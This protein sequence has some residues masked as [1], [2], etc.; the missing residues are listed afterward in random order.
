MEKALI[1]LFLISLFLL[2]KHSLALSCVEPSPPNIAYN[3]YDAVVIGTVEKIK[4]RSHLKT[5]TI[6]VDKSFKAVDQKVITVKED[7]TWGESQ[8]NA[9]YLFYLNK[10]GGKWV[11]PLC[12]S[13]TGNTDIADEFFADKEE[14]TLENADIAVDD[15]RGGIVI[16]FLEIIVVILA[17]GRLKMMKKRKTM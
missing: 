3:E 8:L 11:H 10:E 12:S 5:L 17:I 14:I 9:S 13:T 6:R 4:D 15:T 16:I 7:G 1:A 2:P